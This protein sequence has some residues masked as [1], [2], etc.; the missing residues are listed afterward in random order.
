MQMLTLGYIV[1]IYVTIFGSTTNIVIDETLNNFDQ[2]NHLL[3]QGI[4]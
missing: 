1:L 3:I 2:R 4:L